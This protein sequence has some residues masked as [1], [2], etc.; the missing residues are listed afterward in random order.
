MSPSLSLGGPF[1]LSHSAIRRLAESA[2][3]LKIFP[4]MN[5][6]VDTKFKDVNV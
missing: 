1:V 4:Y 3:A 6:L 2:H 5:V